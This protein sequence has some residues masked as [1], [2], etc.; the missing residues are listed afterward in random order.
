ML[1]GLQYRL[2]RTTRE[3]EQ[4]SPEWRELWRKD[5]EATP[6]QSPEWL[7]PWWHCFGAELRTI[8]L[9]RQ[10]RLVGLLPFYIYREPLTGERQVLPVGVGTSDY[11]DGVFAPECGGEEIA[12]ALDFLSARDDW[13]TLCVSQLRPGSKLLDVLNRGENGV[14]ETQSCA[15]MAAVPMS[16]LPQKIRRNAMYYRNRAQRAGELQFSCADESNREA[17]FRALVNLHGQRWRDRGDP[18][19]FADERVVR[20]HTEALPLLA[21]AGLLRLC[22]LSLGSEIIAVLYGVVDPPGRPQR[23]QY[24]YLPAY[25]VAHADLR[26]GTVLTA[27]AI[28]AAARE[29]VQTIDMLR[30]DEEYKSLWH[31][32]RTP[33]FGFVRSREREL[34]AREVAA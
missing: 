9:Y 16:E 24:F 10:Q 11:L 18:G 20:W 13:D 23:T 31:T 28:D 34:Q 6:F 15:R 22:F 19:V 4:L 3:L 17:V 25:S 2:I 12:C 29:G 1:D 32:E 21:R 14:G 8:A 7:V 5:A 27:L 30:G 33:T 26:P